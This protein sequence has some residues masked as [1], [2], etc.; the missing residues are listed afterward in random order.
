MFNS[1]PRTL[2][3]LAAI[4]LLTREPVVVVLQGLSQGDELR[5]Q[6]VPGSAPHAGDLIRRVR[7][8]RVEYL[9]R[10][11]GTAEQ[12]QLRRDVSVGKNVVRVALRWRPHDLTV[13][14]AVQEERRAG[15]AFLMIQA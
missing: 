5:P 15:P 1:A 4:A 3:G 8:E 9:R 12:V 7:L 2:L 11:A 10:D 13:R 14:L 6:L